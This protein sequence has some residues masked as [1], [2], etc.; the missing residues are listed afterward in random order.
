MKFLV[1]TPKGEPPEMQRA[2][3]EGGEV[4][5]VRRTNPSD[6]D[7]AAAEGDA[8]LVLLPGHLPAPITD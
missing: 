1:E 3:W 2:A 8:L 4:H 5:G 7:A 6:G